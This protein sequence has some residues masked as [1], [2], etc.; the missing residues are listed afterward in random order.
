VDDAGTAG[1][2]GADWLEVGFVKR[3]F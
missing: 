1:G 3:V 2:A